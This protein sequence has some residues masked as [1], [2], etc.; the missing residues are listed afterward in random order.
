MGRLIGI[1]EGGIGEGCMVETACS[2]SEL[3]GGG[4]GRLCRETL[5]VGL[6]CGVGVLGKGVT[7]SSSILVEGERLLC[8]GCG[9]G[10]ARD[11]LAVEADE[12]GYLLVLD[13]L[14]KPPSPSFFASDFRSFA[15]GKDPNACMFCTIP[16]FSI[17][18]SS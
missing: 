15:E 3:R 11:S 7:T 4:G 5:L 9:S 8:G 18:A 17:F 13:D 16:C 14:W 12:A 6:D 2:G 1:G 10:V